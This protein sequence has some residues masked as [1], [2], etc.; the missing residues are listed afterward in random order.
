M[1]RE[2]AV[3]RFQTVISGLSMTKQSMRD[4]CDINVI[5]RGFERTGLATHVNERQGEYGDFSRGFDFHDA[6]NRVRGATEMFMTLPSKIRANFRHDP[7]YFLEFVSDPANAQAMVDMG[8][9]KAPVPAA[10]S[11]APVP[12][13]APVPVVP[14]T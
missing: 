10:V 12:N 13:A 8:L 7:G 3:P 6:M 2:R 9:K 1:A 14:A 4:E 5:M 11:P